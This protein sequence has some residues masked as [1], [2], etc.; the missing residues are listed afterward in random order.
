MIVR[1]RRERAQQREGAWN[2]IASEQIKVDKNKPTNNSVGKVRFTFALAPFSYCP[3]FRRSMR[4]SSFG[5]LT[6]M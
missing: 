5:V 6:Q 1:K 2:Y 4:P 3:I